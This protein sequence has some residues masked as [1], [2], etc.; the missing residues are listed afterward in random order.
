MTSEKKQ[1]WP[2]RE[3]D[4]EHNSAMGFAESS[5]FLP[6]SSLM[7]WNYTEEPSAGGLGVLRAGESPPVLLSA[8]TPSCRL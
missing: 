8:L 5:T 6:L 7:L 2:Q 3:A 1:E 4:E